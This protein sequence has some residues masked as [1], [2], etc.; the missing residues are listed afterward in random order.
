VK[1]ARGLIA[2][3]PLLLFDEPT[4]SL[5]AENRDVVTDLIVQARERGAAI[6]GILHDEEPRNRVATRRLELRPPRRN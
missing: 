2:G 6:V 5:D 1:I 3:H 4:A